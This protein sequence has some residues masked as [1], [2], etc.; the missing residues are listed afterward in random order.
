M[1]GADAVPGWLP[2]GV[3]RD[4]NGYLRTSA[5]VAPEWAAERRPFALETSV[6]GIIPRATS[7]AGR[8]N[9][10]RQG[11]EGGMVIAHAHQDLALR[12]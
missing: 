6:P 8:S 9:G 12:R 11:G 3:A 7:G 2:P 5:D 1:I 4:V 10:S